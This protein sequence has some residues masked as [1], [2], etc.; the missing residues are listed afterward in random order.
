MIKSAEEILKKD[1]IIELL[2]RKIPLTKVDI[3]L[4][5]RA[6]A[7][8]FID[9]AANTDNE[10]TDGAGNGP[11]YISVPRDSILKIKQLIK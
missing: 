2:E 6:F 3:I 11:D 10:F 5:M 7:K 8:Q 1:K 4:V 9:L